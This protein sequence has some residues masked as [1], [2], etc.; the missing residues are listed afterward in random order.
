MATLQHALGN[1]KDKG[2]FNALE[3][4]EKL[5][6]DELDRLG[7]LG[8]TTLASG[9]RFDA[10]VTLPTLPGGWKVMYVGVREEGRYGKLILQPNSQWAQRLWEQGQTLFVSKY[11]S[12]PKHQEVWMKSKIRGRYDV[13]ALEKVASVL[14]DQ[15][16]LR[17]YL[18]FDFRMTQDE[19]MM[20]DARNE[21]RHHLHP[22]SRIA[23]ASII[24]ELVNA[25]V[26]DYPGEPRQANNPPPVP[27]KKK[28]ARGDVPNVTEAVAPVKKMVSG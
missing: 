11:L 14:A 12:D 8:E 1:L 19:G 13:K 27:K 25:G 2:A 20:W 7:S 22:L 17:L 9:Y 15:R 10:N 3:R 26:V 5:T 16:L 6:A 28:T 21:V 18:H 23:L 24:Q 4:I